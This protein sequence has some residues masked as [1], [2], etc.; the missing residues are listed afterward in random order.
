MSRRSSLTIL[1]LFWLSSA[2]AYSSELVVFG[3]NVQI[4]SAL[5][6]HYTTGMGALVVTYND[7][8]GEVPGS[9]SIRAFGP[10]DENPGS[11]PYFEVRK[12][13]EE[14]YG[15]L[16]VFS[17]IAHHKTSHRESRITI[18]TDRSLS[19]M[20]QGD[21]ASSWRDTFSGCTQH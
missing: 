6:A 19:V 15:S 16:S 8:T 13:G 2:T 9:L 17:Y 3:C 14:T 18:V 11:G 4:P 1:I 12:A 20:I 10:A 7:D 21:M 5:T